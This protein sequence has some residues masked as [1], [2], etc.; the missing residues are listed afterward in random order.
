MYILNICTKYDHNRSSSFGESRLIKIDTD[1]QTD[2]HGGSL[3]REGSA[4]YGLSVAAALCLRLMRGRENIESTKSP[5]ELDYYT[6]LAY[7]Q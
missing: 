4:S 6:S 7:A 2:G 3:S 1:R 5:D